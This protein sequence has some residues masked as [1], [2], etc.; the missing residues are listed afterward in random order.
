MQIAE[1]KSVHRENPSPADISM[2]ITQLSAKFP[3]VKMR[4][5]SEA[6]QDMRPE[7]A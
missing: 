5:M 1:A 6:L 4:T 3:D 7:I 2:D